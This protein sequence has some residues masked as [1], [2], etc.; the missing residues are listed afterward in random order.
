M[1]QLTITTN[2]LVHATKT[3]ELAVDAR[4]LWKRLE[5]K[6]EFTNWI[7]NRI[8][9]YQFIE[10][11]DFVT[12]DKI[13][14]REIGATKITEYKL[15]IDMAKELC[16]IENNDK[17]RKFRKY[18]IEIEKKYKN[19]YNFSDP[20]ESARLF[21]EAETRRR[22]LEK[23]VKKLEHIRDFRDEIM[24]SDNLISVSDAGKTLKIGVNKFFKLLR[25]KKIL[26]YNY[27]KCNVPFQSYIDRGYFE[28]KQ[29]PYK[30]DKT[31][32]DE[33]LCFSQKTYFTLKGLE[34]V[35]KK[36]KEWN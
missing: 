36:L 4:S 9:K 33:K 32:K 29:S 18:F 28:V 8:Q 25:N 31:N 16:M 5:C 11:E 21:I 13:I 3:S 17:G 6:Q 15:T 14:K 12:F 10:H 35:C 20:I 7:K 30:K 23:E 2:K 22:S 19:K 26:F 34:W 27:N 1:D 24:N